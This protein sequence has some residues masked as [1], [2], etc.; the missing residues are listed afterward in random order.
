MLNIKICTEGPSMKHLIICRTNHEVT[1][2]KY[3]QINPALFVGPLSVRPLKTH[4]GA[5]P[6]KCKQ[7]DFASSQA[8][9]LRTHLKV[10]SGEKSNKCNQ[11]GFAF[12]Q[13]SNLKTHLK[14]NGKINATNVA[15]HPLGKSEV[16]MKMSDDL[17][18]FACGD[19]TFQ[20]CKSLWIF[21]SASTNLRKKSVNRDK[22]S[23]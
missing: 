8:S 1:L 17:W 18:H 13:A 12:T 23:R 19:H 20:K 21:F 16:N 4:S 11:C 2:S 3:H 9:N 5:K 22:K 14:Y 10:H 7:C 6:N 15:S